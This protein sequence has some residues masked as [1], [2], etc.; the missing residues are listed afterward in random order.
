M[1]IRVRTVLAKIATLNDIALGRD[2]ISMDLIVSF[3][4]KSSTIN[5]S[6]ARIFT[7]MIATSPILRGS[8]WTMIFTVTEEN[9]VESK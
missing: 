2:P 8:V 6:P 5:E 3:T 9:T 4:L 7:R 1:I